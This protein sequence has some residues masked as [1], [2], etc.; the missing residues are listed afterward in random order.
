MNQSTRGAACAAWLLPFACWAGGDTQTEVGDFADVFVG[1]SYAS[2]NAGAVFDLTATQPVTGV[3]KFDESLGT[4]VGVTLTADFEVLAELEIDGGG[5]IDS[6]AGVAAGF[7]LEFLRGAIVYRP[8][9][10]PTVEV[11]ASAD[12]AP[13]VSCSASA[14]AGACAGLTTGVQSV[15]GSVELSALGS[16]DPSDFVG[17]GDVTALLAELRAPSGGAFTLT[18]LSD[19]SA[20]LAATV[21]RLSLT[22]EYDFIPVPEPAAAVGC[23]AVATTLSAAG[24]RARTKTN[25]LSSPRRNS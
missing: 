10:S 7:V 12:Q 8:A 18:N 2:T 23:V 3:A 22:L 20:D 6:E 15:G 19:A 16:F 13:G 25:Q 17:A 9:G 14:S 11:L 1:T 24:R 21:S 4:L 5:A